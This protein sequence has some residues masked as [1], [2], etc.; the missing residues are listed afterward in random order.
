MRTKKAGALMSDYHP[1][2][3]PWGQA[4]YFGLTHDQV[5]ESL[6]PHRW[7]LRRARRE[8]LQAEPFRGITTDGQVVPGR[9]TLRDEGRRRPAFWRRSRHCSAG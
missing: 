6:P 1:F 9:F 5:L 3:P 7:E 8:S 2:V 4:R